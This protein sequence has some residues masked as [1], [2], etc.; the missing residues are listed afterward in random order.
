MKDG[1]LHMGKISEDV[2]QYSGTH[3]DAVGCGG[4]FPCQ[5][6]LECLL[7]QFSL[8]FVIP[9][10]SVWPGIKLAWAMPELASFGTCSESGTRYSPRG[11]LGVCRAYNRVYG[12]LFRVSGCRVKGF[13]GVE[14]LG[15]GCFQG[16]G[17]R[18][19][20]LQCHSWSFR[21]KFLYLEN[22]A[23]IQSAEPHML[24]L[25]HYLVQ[26]PSGRCCSGSEETLVVSS[27]V[28]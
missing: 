19:L 21:R 23:A 15:C 10:V 11:G 18:S 14:N 9:R 2:C 25:M 5:A 8:P 4:G 6:G 20:G 16:L 12:F 24:R 3:T 28:V 13:V 26:D 17:F 27:C 7:P 1:L 22:C